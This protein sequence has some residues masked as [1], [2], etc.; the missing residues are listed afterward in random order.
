M[1]NEENNQQ[2]E[3]VSAVLKVFAIVNALAEHKSL[4]ITELAQIVHGSKST[5]YRFLQTM[6]MLGFVSQEGDHDRYSLTLKLFEVSAKALDHIDLISLA[7]PHMVR[8]GE[9]TKEAL[10]LGI[11]DGDN[12]VYIHKVDAQYNLRM[13]SRIGGRNPLY[14]T[15]IGKVLLAERSENSI[16]NILENTVFIPSTMKTHTSIESLLTD[17]KNVESLGYGIDNEEQ[18]EG[19]RC[20]AAPIYDRLGNV[21]AGL[22]LSSPTVRHTSEKFEMHIELLKEA[23]AQISS[24]LGYR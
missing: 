2:I 20:I 8:I 7:E 21:I 15:A 5:V 3:P 11:R 4:G 12:I 6:K 16:R 14:S 18:E 22:S 19:L 1:I 9:L 17:L 13:E 23:A 24:K 10:H